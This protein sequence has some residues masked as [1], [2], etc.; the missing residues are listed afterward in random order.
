MVLESKLVSNMV[1]EREVLDSSTLVVL[2]GWRFQEDSIVDNTA[3][4]AWSTI[5]WTCSGGRLETGVVGV[6]LGWGVTVVFA[7]GLVGE[8]NCVMGSTTV[9]FDCWKRADT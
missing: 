6:V 3:A 2:V 8:V 5:A 9:Y 7:G 4:A 1:L